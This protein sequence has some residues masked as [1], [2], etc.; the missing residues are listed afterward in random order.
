MLFDDVDEPVSAASGSLLDEAVVDGS[1]SGSL[2]RLPDAIA[3]WS[4]CANCEDDDAGCAVVAPTGALAFATVAEMRS[5][6]C[7]MRAWTEETPSKVIH[8]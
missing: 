8:L 1:A 6:I 3:S 5:W 2:P 4:S 7:A